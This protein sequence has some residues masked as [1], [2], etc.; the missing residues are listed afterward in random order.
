[1]EGAEGVESVGCGVW[2]AEREEQSVEFGVRSVK[3]RVWSV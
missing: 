2:N 3:S 1:M